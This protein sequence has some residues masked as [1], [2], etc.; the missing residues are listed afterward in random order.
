MWARQPV[1]KPVSAAPAGGL[2]FPFHFVSGHSFNHQISQYLQLLWILY[3]IVT[4][5][6]STEDYLPFQEMLLLDFANELLLRIAEYLESERDIN[7]FARVNHRLYSLLNNYLYLYNVQQFG[8]SALFWAALHGQ[9][10]TAQKSLR[11][12]AITQATAM[13]CYTPLFLAAGNGNEAVVKLLL[14]MDS[15]DPDSKDSEWGQTPLSWAAAYGHEAVVKLLLATDGVDPES[16]DTAFGKTPL[17]WAAG[18]GHEAVVKLLL[19]TIGINPDS[20]GKWGQTPLSLAAGSGHEEVVKLL[21]ATENVD[22]DSRDNSGKTPLSWAAASGHE[23]VVKLLLATENV[24]P[25]SRDNSGKTP[26]SWAAAS[27]HKAMAKLLLV[28][29]GIDLNSKDNDSEGMIR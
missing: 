13:K 11:Q 10:G 7:A 2:S 20:K 18:S 27:G 17:S 3:N 5:H 19:A 8:S 29:D 12:G 23:E 14:T 16:K 6:L 1:T 15:V 24:D 28:M 4:I 26:M 22:P 9:E 21:L 25:D